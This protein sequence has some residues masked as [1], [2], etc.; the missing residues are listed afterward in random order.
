MKYLIVLCLTAAGSMAHGQLPD[1]PLHANGLLYSDTLMGRLRHL[2]DSMRKRARLARG[3]GDYYSPKQTTG[4]LVRLDT[5]HIYEAFE[6]LRRGI[7]IADFVS[8]YP[9]AEVDNKILVVLVEGPGYRVAGN[10]YYY[11]IMADDAFYSAGRIILPTDEHYVPIA[12]TSINYRVEENA[13]INGNCVY[14]VS[15]APHRY[16]GKF[17]NEAYVFAF[18]LDGVP[19]ATRLPKPAARL[20][21]YRDR[22]V[23]STTGVYYKN[24][25][26]ASPDL[27]NVDFGPAQKAFDNYMDRKGDSA[28]AVYRHKYPYEHPKATAIEDFQVK[29]RYQDSLTS[30]TGFTRLL[31]AAVAEVEEQ[32]YYPFIYLERYMDAYAP[33]AALEI[34]RRWQHVMTDNFDRLNPRLYAMHIAYLAAELGNWPVFLQAQLSVAVDPYGNNT[35]PSQP[36]HRTTF[37]RELEALNIEVDDILLGRVLGSS[38]VDPSFGGVKLLGGA[39]ALE[40][41]DRNRL[42]EKVLQLIADKGLDDYDRLDMHYLFLNYVSFLAEGPERRRALTRLERADGTLPGYL[43]AT[44]KVRE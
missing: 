33:R 35:G 26:Y 43:S 20:I 34:R 21:G 28:L 11:N 32:H 22:M 8:K 27:R 31:A 16:R 29:R 30:D 38:W 15:T 36:G 9:Q 12:D 41:G 7:S 39:L 2:A 3:E 37:L 13:G 25:Q 5:G 14:S 44:V 24:A 10:A 23:D 18:Y 40:G 19:A 4:R 42:E 1:F 17:S 6:D